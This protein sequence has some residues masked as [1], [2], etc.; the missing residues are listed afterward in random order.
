[1]P[2]IVDASAI[3]GCVLP[4]EQSDYS[5]ALID[6]LIDEPGHAPAILWFEV[7]NALTISVTKRQRITADEAL[8]ALAIFDYFKIDVLPNPDGEQTLSMATR[9][10]LT[11]YDAAYLVAA[12][13]NGYRLATRDK[14]LSQAASA[15]N[16]ILL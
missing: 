4:D 6:A 1:M 7:L 15:E 8:D 3:L 13:S 2:L 11:A 5:D 10:D 9:H 14:R 12:K 16:V